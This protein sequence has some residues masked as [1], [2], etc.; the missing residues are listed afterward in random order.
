[1]SELLTADSNPTPAEPERPSPRKARAA[2][3]K[4]NR[5]SAFKRV[6]AWGIDVSITGALATLVS[7]A[8]GNNVQDPFIGPALLYM[9]SGF[10]YRTAAESSAWQATLGKRLFGMIVVRADGTL[11]PWNHAAWRNFLRMTV[12]LT[13]G[14]AYLMAAILPQQTTGHDLLSFTRV[15][16]KDHTDS[17][18]LPGWRPSSLVGWI[19]PTLGTICSLMGLGVLLLVWAGVAGGRGHVNAA[20]QRLAPFQAVIEKHYAAKQEPPDSVASSS[21][22]DDDLLRGTGISAR[23]AQETGAIL[24]TLPETIAY[25][26]LEI[27]YLPANHVDTGKDT[28]MWVCYPKDGFH[29][30]L[31]PAS[32]TLTPFTETSTHR[33][34]KRPARQD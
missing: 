9:I 12:L 7:K 21:I 28:P 29:P 14:I 15:V 4:T 1:M 30:L 20:Y 18:A 10:I 25:G 6:A 33:I 17:T 2:F 34:R 8:M 5:V 3:F 11:L 19:A 27:R 32:C 31:I 23:Y 13:S 26:H 22:H 24:L 16:K